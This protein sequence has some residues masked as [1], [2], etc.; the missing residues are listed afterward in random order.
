MLKINFEK[1]LTTSDAANNSL[2]T[3]IFNS[4]KKLGRSFVIHAI[5]RV[6]HG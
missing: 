3:V 1:N 5:K 4:K 6:S 2:E